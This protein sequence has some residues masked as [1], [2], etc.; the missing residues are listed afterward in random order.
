ML[1]F[2]ANIDHR[3]CKDY[4]IVGNISISTNPSNV[5][6]D[7]KY[8][9]MPSVINDMVSGLCNVNWR[10]FKGIVDPFIGT[11]VGEILNTLLTTFFDEIAMQDLF[12]ICNDTNFVSVTPC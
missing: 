9:K 6:M 4:L 2:I 1:S 12:N 8:P 5:K 7:F 11:Y 3:D 10:I